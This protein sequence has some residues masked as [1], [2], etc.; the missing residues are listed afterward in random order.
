M[1]STAFLAFSILITAASVGYASP[2]GGSDDYRRYC[3]ACHGVAAD[4]NGPVANVLDP[5]PPALTRLHRNYGSPLGTR[6]V[7]YVMG[8]KMPRAHGTSEMPVWGRNLEEKDGTDPQAVR[9]I[10][11]IAE[12]LESLQSR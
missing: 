3:S 2:L 7:A 11:R 5:R 6:F 10:W 12:Y 1:R 4:G 9:T 8:T